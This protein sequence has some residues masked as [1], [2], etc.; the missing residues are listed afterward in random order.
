MRTRERRRSRKAILC[1]A[2]FIKH[3]VHF[4]Y[5]LT[6]LDNSKPQLCPIHPPF[7]LTNSIKDD[8]VCSHS[9]SS[10]YINEC[11][12]DY[13]FHLHLSSCLSHQTILG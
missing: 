12:N 8:S 9:I 13:Q 4:F 2:I 1:R 6:Y 3:H 11:A 5:Y 10:S 7:S